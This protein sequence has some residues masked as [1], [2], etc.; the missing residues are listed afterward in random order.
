MV[1]SSSP[2]LRRTQRANALAAAVMVLVLAGGAAWWWFGSGA[3][4]SPD[5]APTVLAQRAWRFELRGDCM[6]QPMELPNA[7]TKSWPAEVDLAGVVTLTEVQDTRGTHLLW[8]VAS[9]A[10]S[11]LRVLGR[12]T[13]APGPSD[14][15]A[16]G[17][18]FPATA[19]LVS[20]PEELRLRM[21]PGAHPNGLRV[22][23]LLASAFLPFP[24]PARPPNVEEEGLFGRVLASHAR[25]A[26]QVVRTR[27]RAVTV[28]ALNPV[29]E[30]AL[31]AAEL[32]GR[33]EAA[34]DGRGW[35][36][37]LRGEEALRVPSAGGAW[38]DGAFSFQLDPM[39]ATPSVRAA[40]PPPLDAQA[41]AVMD[42]AQVADVRQMLEQDAAGMTAEQL[43][44]DVARWGVMGQ[45]PD[46]ARWLWRA[47][48]RLTLDPALCRRLVPLFR[49]MASQ[50]GRVLILDLLV[51]AGHPVA[52]EVLRDLLTESHGQHAD[53][54]YSRMYSRLS[55]LRQP[56]AETL[57]FAR[58][59]HS[60]PN[61]Q[62]HTARLYALGSVAGA[63][64]HHGATDEADEA[65]A[66]LARALETTQGA[67]KADLLEALGNAGLSSTAPAVHAAATDDNPEVRQAAAGALRDLA[68]ESSRALLV[69][70]VGDPDPSVGN[71]ALRSLGTLD[72]SEE[73]ASGLQALLVAGRIAPSNLDA[74][75]SLLAPHAGDEPVVDQMLRFILEQ[76][77]KNAQVKV[78][79][80]ALLQ[81]P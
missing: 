54:D 20:E 74:L 46:H 33:A 30:G 25:V 7:P 24:D 10:R 11:E 44:A 66:P 49:S 47:T 29:P 64:A 43:L 78:R 76:P 5:A 15:G 2:P 39:D 57:R 27:T 38:V 69:S 45:V 18:A 9:L 8:T 48:A 34:V 68:D 58:E 63:R 72:L 80:R 13:L 79:I 21:A 23:H 70:L 77:L 42:V 22:L 67:A 50:G 56:T 32:T 36:V 6:V 41:R 52:Q 1:R 51:G 4:S 59:Q 40:V 61:R 17:P 19:E 37:A 12:N 35:P 3:L 26:D 16:T 60:A 53:A 65:V 31:E 62:A 28:R 75:V 55:L 81:Q 14:G 73:E 71:R